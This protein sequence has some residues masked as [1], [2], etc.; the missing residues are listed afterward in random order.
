[1]QK[2]ALHSQ[3]KLWSLDLTMPLGSKSWYFSKLTT[4][5]ELWKHMKCTNAQVKAMFALGLTCFSKAVASWAE[6]D[7]HYHCFEKTAKI[8]QFKKIV[9]LNSTS[10]DS[11]AQICRYFMYS[12]N[13][14]PVPNYIKNI[15]NHLLLPTKF[16]NYHN[17]YIDLLH[18]F[19]CA[20]IF[21]E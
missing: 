15:I 2:P 18:F 1:M 3:S 7:E 19:K 21:Y 16:S 13:L 4:H 10:I 6:A 11:R 14:L 5:Q 8:W 20:V 17:F 12:Q 9:S